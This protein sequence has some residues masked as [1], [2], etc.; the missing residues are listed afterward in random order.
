MSRATNP[1]ENGAIERREVMLDKIERATEL[2]MM[3]LAFVMIPLLV[4]PL[5]WDLSS[6][7]EAVVLA[8]DGFI[9]AL[10]AT[11]L[12]IKVAI[13]PQRL[14]YVRQHWL[15]VMIVLV[16]FVR[17]LRL[18]RIILFGSRV[19]RGAVRLARIDFLVAYAIGLV[20]LVATIITLVE[21]G[22]NSELDS[23]SDALW[24][25]VVTV[26]TAGYGDVV[27]E[28]QIGRAFAYVLMVGG[29]GIFGAI[30]ANFA[31]ILVRKDDA[32]SPSLD[33]LVKEVQLMRE[34]LTQLRERSADQE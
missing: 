30:T 9:W 29:I 24:W 6:R 1:T 31:S 25:A 2:P 26:T 21:R 7:A 15:D 5:F 4:A 12:A 20:L 32:D 17:P 8:L 14:K 18:L 10:F 33:Y 34:E 22:G 23:F 19:Y 16:P 3:V 13:A 27:P 11:D 28:T